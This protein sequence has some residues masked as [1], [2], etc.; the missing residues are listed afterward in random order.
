MASR[1]MP[2]IFCGGS[3]SIRDRGG[4]WVQNRGA[5][6]RVRTCEAHPEEHKFETR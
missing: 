3:T 2:C 4:S 6:V 1:P 5:F